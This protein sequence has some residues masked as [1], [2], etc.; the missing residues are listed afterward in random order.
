MNAITR[1]LDTYWSSSIGKK[2]I[3]AITGL[4]LVLFLGGH[5][6]GNL[7]V[8]M[9]QEAFND[10]AQLLHHLL[11]GAGIWI[12]RIGLL[13]AVA[14]HIAATIALTRQNKAAR[15]AYEYQATIQASKSSRIMIWTGLT[16]LAFVI[17]HLLHFTVRAG[18]EYNNPALYTDLAYKAATGD[19]RQNAW[20]M[21]IDGFSVW[22]VVLFYIVAMTM[23]CSHLSHGVGAIFQTLGL[24]S[25]KSASAIDLISKGYAAVIWIGF[26]SIPIAILCGYG[27]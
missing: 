13:V 26:V 3:V 5:M 25:K 22:Y 12:A 11:H 10:Y 9:G 24:R 27:R 4:V 17:Y 23:L 8:F 18:N 16:I 19:Y 6:T 2:L 14:L 20:K 7:L 21:V 1:C 15:K